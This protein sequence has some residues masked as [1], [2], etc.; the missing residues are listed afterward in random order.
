MGDPGFSFYLYT[1]APGVT[2]SEVY[3]LHY[4]REP[5]GFVLKYQKLRDMG[6]TVAASKN[7]KSILAGIEWNFRRN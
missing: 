1:L 3:E 4:D 2:Q 6:P 7:V 5:Y